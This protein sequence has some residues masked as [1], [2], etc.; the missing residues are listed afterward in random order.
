MGYTENH[1]NFPKPTV[2]E[3]A[4]GK[5]HCPRGKQA[6]GRKMQ[7]ASLYGAFTL[8]ELLAVIAAIGILITLL[9]PA[10][11]AAREAARRTSCVS[12]LKQLGMAAHHHHDARGFLPPEGVGD[13]RPPDLR[14]KGLSFRGWLL[15]YME[16]TPLYDH[17]DMRA[18]DATAHEWLSQYRISNFLCP[19]STEEYQNWQ[20]VIESDKYASHYFGIAGALG[21]NPETGTQYR[22][23]PIKTGPM[24][25]ATGPFANTGVT[26]YNSSVSFGDI[27]DGT[28]NTFLYGEISWHGYGGYWNWTRGATSDSGVSDSGVVDSDVV[29]SGVSGA[30]PDMSAISLISAKAMAGNW[31]INVGS[32]MAPLTEIAQD[33]WDQANAATVTVSLIAGPGTAPSISLS[34]GHGVA[35]FGSNHAGGANF[36]LCDGSARFWSSSSTTIVLMAAATREEGETVTLP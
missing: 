35:G 36:I 25:P 28:S 24:F 18:T 22:T 14:G 6:V 5:Q 12:N 7:P 15:P 16:Q 30:P 29:D 27:L 34:A 26:Y 11:Q 20:G 10:V 1:W 21:V 31:P 32:R 4:T 19:S 3:F 13:P 33:Y 23:D 8:V 9:L 17:I 2:R